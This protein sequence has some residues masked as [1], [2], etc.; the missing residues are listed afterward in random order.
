MRN[1]LGRLNARSA[2]DLDRIAAFWRVSLGRG[3]KH[4]QVGSL[5]RAMIDPAA[6]RDAWERLAPDEATVVRSLATGEVENAA[7]LAE[8]GKILEVSTAEA[9][10]TAASLY[11]HGILAREGGGAEL[12]VGEAPRLF[13]PRELAVQFRRVLDEI[14]LGDTSRLPLASLIEWFDD[15]EIDDAA[16]AW[17]VTVV[18]GAR[19]RAELVRR[20]LRQASDASRIERVVK[21]LSPDAQRIWNVTLGSPDGQAARLAEVRIGTGMAGD[22]AR[23]AERFRHALAQLER[24]MLVWHTYRQDGG[25]WLFI[26]ADIRQPRPVE[27]APL[28]PLVPVTDEMIGERPW[29]HPQAAAWDLLTLLRDLASTPWP[30]EGEPPRA[31]LRALNQRLWRSGPELPP[32]GYLP[33]LIALA[34]AE[35]LI[36][37]DDG[38]PPAMVVTS[39][40]RQWRERTFPEQFERLRWWWGNATEWIEGR[41]AGQVEVWGVDW[42]QVRRRL[43]ALLGDPD[44]GLSGGHWYTLDSVAMRI[45]ARDPD[46]LGV[47]FTAATARSGGDIGGA[48]G[49]DEARAA[50]TAE[51]VAI[52]LSTA[53]AWFALVDIADVPGRTRAVRLTALGEQLSRG[54]TPSEPDPEGAGAGPALAVDDEAVI[55][56]LRPSPLRVWA[57]GAFAEQESLG[58]ESR[59]RLTEASV[60]RALAAGFDAGQIDSFLERQGGTPLAGNV[61]QRLETWSRSLRRVRVRRAVVLQP[62]DPAEQAALLSLAAERK[63][64]AVPG[65]D[66][67]VTILLTQDDLD[68]AEVVAA[69]R[70]AGCTPLTDGRQPAP[71]ARPEPYR[72]R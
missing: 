23:S 50:A 54:G 9:R 44:I 31:R 55:T 3:E 10:E 26:P 70:G 14:D 8:L 25:R 2:T 17:G 57:L 39:A 37:S 72:T 62:D 69:L 20:L 40:S 22:D 45:A 60:G 52:E 47:A 19:N 49:P 64:S 4:A 6:V 34:D 63:W 66:G 48:I 27:A 16:T 46:L 24:A 28:P 15:G 1:L 30:M 18:P 12:P 21:A 11:R 56:L 7:T 58:R 41:D 51:M 33:F 13:L 61:A 67:T 32:A 59:F 38:Q 71:G 43:I 42:R 29:R 35:G 68:D 5:Y 53:C 36:A 65:P